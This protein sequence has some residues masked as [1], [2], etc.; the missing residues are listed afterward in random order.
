M[1]QAAMIDRSRVNAAPEF[2]ASRVDG[3]DDRIRPVEN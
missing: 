2:I 1:I 3:V